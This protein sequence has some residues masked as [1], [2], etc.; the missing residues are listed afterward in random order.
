M[1]V[2]LEHR[3]TEIDER[4]KDNA[5]R[6]DKIE[7]RQDDLEELTSAVKILAYR[8]DSVEKDV[9]EI[10]RDVK[11]IH[12]KPVKRWNDIL[13]K[14]LWFIIAAFLGFLLSRIGL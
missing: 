10:K 6:I 13:D 2:A 3:L 5:K 12:D 8:E 9:K 4:S 1:E 7:K 11:A 14:A